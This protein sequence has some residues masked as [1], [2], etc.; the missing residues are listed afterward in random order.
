MTRGPQHCV[1]P[2]WTHGSTSLAACQ[3]KCA[4]PLR[5]TAPHHGVQQR[6]RSAE[7]NLTDGFNGWSTGGVELTTMANGGGRARSMHGSMKHG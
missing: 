2:Q 6:E 3:S 1:G 7:G 5:G 4:R